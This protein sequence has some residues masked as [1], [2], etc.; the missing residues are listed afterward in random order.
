MRRHLDPTIKEFAQEAEVARGLRFHTLAQTSL[1]ELAKKIARDRVLYPTPEL[2]AAAF[3]TEV[4]RLIENEK[5]ASGPA[6]ML[7]DLMRLHDDL[8]SRY[9]ERK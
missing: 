1:G 8:Q 4:S 7:G 9:Q 5:K 6:F 2:Q 3:S